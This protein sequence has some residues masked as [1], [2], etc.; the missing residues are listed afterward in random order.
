MTL[1]ALP[2]VA[3]AEQYRPSRRSPPTVWDRQFEQ[4]M[5]VR[6]RLA[7]ASGQRAADR[8]GGGR[9]A[10]SR[11]SADRG[12]AG[13][14][15][16]ASARLRARHADLGLVDDPVRPRAGR[17]AVRHRGLGVVARRA[18]SAATRFAAIARRGARPGGA[19]RVPGGARRV[20]DR[21][22]GAR[23]AC[24]APRPLVAA[25]LAGAAVAADAA[26]RLQHARVR[27]AVPARLSGRHRLRR[28][29]RGA[30]RA[31]QPQIRRPVGDHRRA[32]AAACCGS[33]RS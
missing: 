33:R 11:A 8:A 26:D 5:T 17:R 15:L 16:F 2:A 31:D 29:E 22:C 23:F 27:H 1:L 28:H 14:A 12:S 32:C 30:V 13:G 9:A 6:L 20:G 18:R 7:V 10:R 25:A 21:A 3:L 24:V 19:D 4:W